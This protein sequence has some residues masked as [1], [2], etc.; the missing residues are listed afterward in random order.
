M[1]ELCDFSTFITLAGI[2]TIDSVRISVEFV[3]LSICVDRQPYAG[4][5]VRARQLSLTRPTS[6]WQETE[7][8]VTGISDLVRLQLIENQLSSVTLFRLKN[9]IR[10]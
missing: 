9:C 4:T 8:K 1:T 10:Y 3:A 5:S 2:A 6:C 7:M